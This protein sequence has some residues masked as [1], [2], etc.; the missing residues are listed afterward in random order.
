MKIVISPTTFKGTIGVIDACI[1]IIRGVRQRFPHADVVQHPVSDGGDGF[2]ESLLFN[3]GGKFVNAIVTGPRGR[4]RQTICGILGNGT[5]VVE[6]AKASGF[7]MLAQE[8]KNPLLTTSYGTGELIQGL[9]KKGIQEI[10]IGVGGSATIDVGV[11]CMK[12]LG[13]RFLDDK[14]N[15]VEYVGREIAKVRTIDK[16]RISKEV[17]NC[18][19][20]V[21]ADVNNVLLGD[22]GAVFTYGK[23]KGLRDDDAPFMEDAVAH[24]AQV[25]KAECGRDITTIKGGGAAGGIG[26][27]LFGVLKA[28]IRDGAELFFRLS[29]FR[30]RIKGAHAIITGEGRFDSLTGYGKV[31]QRILSIGREHNMFVAVLAGEITDGAERL[32]SDGRSFGIA[33]TP[34]GTSFS[35]AKERVHGLLQRG[36]FDAMA[37]LGKWLGEAQ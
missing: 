16:S 33:I 7:S 23:Q 12:A 36:S 27:G 11:G 13:V 5:G 28:E 35:E 24:M 34:A 26:A 21:A 15:E 3:C 9:V 22:E 4:Q 31:V 32:F 19:L 10:V 30:E 25:I 1:A 14:G 6:M 8:E 18:R 20:I 2:L 17:K 37:K 29:N